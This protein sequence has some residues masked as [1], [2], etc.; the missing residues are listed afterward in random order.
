[1]S[2]TFGHTQSAK[3]EGQGRGGGGVSKIKMPR[4]VCLG[5]ENGPIFKDIFS[6][7]TYPQ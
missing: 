1:M 3:E 4:C 6:C 5:F 7:K 2:I